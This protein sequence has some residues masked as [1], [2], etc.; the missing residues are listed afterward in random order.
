MTSLL[1]FSGFAHDSQG[2]LTAIKRLALM[3]IERGLNFSFRAIVSGL[4]GVELGTA[5]LTDPEGARRVFYD[6]KMAF[7]HDPSLTQCQE[8][9]KPCGFQTTPLPNFR[10][11]DTYNRLW[12]LERNSIRN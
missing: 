7:R 1:V 12:K 11:K 10:A 5:M 4:I 6:P 9:S 8:S 2:V 3:G